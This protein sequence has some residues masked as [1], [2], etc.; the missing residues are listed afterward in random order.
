MLC[1]H[2]AKTSILAF[3]RSQKSHSRPQDTSQQASSRSTDPACHY[4]HSVYMYCMAHYTTS[5]NFQGDSAHGSEHA[6]L[7]RFSESLVETSFSRCLTM[8]ALAI[9]RSSNP[10]TERRSQRPDQHPR[11]HRLPINLTH[12]P[13][14]N[15]PSRDRRNANQ[16]IPL[17]L[18]QKFPQR[19]FP[20]HRAPGTRHQADPPVH[21]AV[22]LK[23]ASRFTLT[24]PRAKSAVPLPH[25]NAAN[26]RKAYLYHTARTMGA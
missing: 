20:R 10:A 19:R 21:Y 18:T 23:P 24:H 15:L 16:S 14:T 25:R 22:H 6:R 26:N 2:D 3:H 1:F 11:F 12:L 13:I 8:R 17:S 5:G 4:I 7:T 9:R